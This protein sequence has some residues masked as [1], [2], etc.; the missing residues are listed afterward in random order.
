M[1]IHFDQIPDEG[2]PASGR[3]A[4]AVFDLDPSD[5]IKPTQDAHYDVTLYKF[6][7][8]IRIEGDLRGTFDLQCGLCLKH[9]PYQADFSRWSSEYEFEEDET[10]FDLHEV[11]REDFLMALPQAPQC[12][13]L[14]QVNCPKRELLTSIQE[15]ADLEDEEQ[16]DEPDDRWDALDGLR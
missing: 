5:A 3:L 1:R 6:S 11:L 10:S 13:E 2:L 14:G 12:E 7:D 16:A 15:Q 9:L 4:P 8:A